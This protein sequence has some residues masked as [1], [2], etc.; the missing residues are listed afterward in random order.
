MKRIRFALLLIAL[1]PLVSGCQDKEHSVVSINRYGNG[2]PFIELNLYGN[3]LQNILEAK[4]DFV[5]EVYSPTCESCINLE[6]ILQK[7]AEKTNKIIYRLNIR[8][9]TEDDYNTMLREPYPDIFA[10]EYVPTIS[11]ISDGKLTY[12]VSP[13]K[14]GTYTGLKSVMNKHFTSSNITMISDISS[15]SDYVQNTKNYICYFYDLT[16]PYSVKY[17]SE[18]IIKNSVAK[19]KTPVLLINTSALKNMELYDVQLYYE[20]DITRFACIVKDGVI[21]KS[22]DYSFDDGTSVQELISVF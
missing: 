16:S 7:Y 21:T 22:I 1:C 11:F 14:F 4:Q 19:N 8:D 13:N 6:P 3:S 20:T 10:S 9:M 5:L 18:H 2:N 12:E 15:F 17:A